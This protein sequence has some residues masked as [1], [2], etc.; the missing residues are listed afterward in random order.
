MPQLC[1]HWDISCWNCFYCLKKQMP[2]Q[3]LAM[4]QYNKHFLHCMVDCFLFS[5]LV[6]F[7][8]GHHPWLSPFFIGWLFLLTNSGHHPSLQPTTTAFL[9]W[10]I[11]CNDF[12]YT[13]LDCFRFSTLVDFFATTSGCHPSLWPN[14][15]CIQMPH[16]I[17]SFFS[18]LFFPNDFW[19]HPA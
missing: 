19:C 14:H 18:I 3:P 2:W 13:T 8:D 7:F 9:H 11:F 10:L 17:V 4:M 15:H 16:L 1:K 5:T 12:F 6:F